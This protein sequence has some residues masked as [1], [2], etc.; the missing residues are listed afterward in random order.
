M[1]P[2]RETPHGDSRADRTA[3][4]EREEGAV[5]P[6]IGLWAKRNTPSGVSDPAPRWRRGDLTWGVEKE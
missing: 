4:D 1:T 5:N 6:L 3:R 2:R